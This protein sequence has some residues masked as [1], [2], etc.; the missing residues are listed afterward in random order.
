MKGLL[1]QHERNIAV[2]PLYGEQNWSRGVERAV[3]GLLSEE[4]ENMVKVRLTSLPIRDSIGVFSVY[5]GRGI[6]GIAE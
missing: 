6:T 3:S 1:G 4:R 2:S 5:S